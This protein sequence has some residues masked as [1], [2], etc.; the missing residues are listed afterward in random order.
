MS[1]NYATFVAAFRTT[2]LCALEPAISAAKCAS[3]VT[4][5]A[6]ALCPAHDSALRSAHRAALISAVFA[7]EH[8]TVI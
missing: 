4:T 7:T 2:E 1:A 3:F 5:Y 6:P 8:S